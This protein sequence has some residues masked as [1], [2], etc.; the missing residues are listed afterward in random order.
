MESKAHDSRILLNE[1]KCSTPSVMEDFREL[2][3]PNAIKS[4]FLFILDWFLILISVFVITELSTLWLPIS[5]LLIGSRQRAL[6]NLT[7]ESSHR[8]LFINKRIGDLIGNWLAAYPMF[9]SVESYRNKHKQHHKFLGHKVNDPDYKS[10]LKYGYDDYEHEKYNKIKKFLLILLNKNAIKDSFWASF[11]NPQLILQ[12]I[13]WFVSFFLLLK[14]LMGFDFAVNF[15]FL[16][17]FSKATTYHLI[18]ICAEFLDHS[19]LR[20]QNGIFSYTRNI[21]TPSLIGFLIHPHFDNYHLVHH[22]VPSSPCYNLKKLH[23][24]FIENTT[25]Y[26]EKSHNCQGYILNHHSAFRCWL[27][28]HNSHSV[29]KL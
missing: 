21:T 9:D 3:I 18:R 20:P 2:L 4:L 29:T 11:F 6:S 17:F 19:G 12:F 16:W 10:H 7:H 15:I 24:L 22:L 27:S 26:K 1:L 23:F 13:I 5:V 25:V 14:N 28:N 8:N